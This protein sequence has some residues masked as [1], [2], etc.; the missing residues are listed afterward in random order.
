MSTDSQPSFDL[1]LLPSYFLD[2]Q[3]GTDQ[4]IGWSPTGSPPKPAAYFIAGGS[5][6]R[7]WQP[8]ASQTTVSLDT[9][10]QE[11]YGNA[12]AL[13]RTKISNSTTLTASEKSADLSKIDAAQASL[14][15]EF[16]GLSI[17]AQFDHIRGA[18]Q[19]DHCAVVLQ[20][21]WSA[22]LDTWL[23]AEIKMGFTW[24]SLDV[25][26]PD[27]VLQLL[28]M[29]NN[30]K[31]LEILGD[32]CD[33]LS[34]G[35]ELIQFI[36]YA[37]K[38]WN[39]AV[40]E[41]CKFVDDGGRLYFPVVVV[42]GLVRL[43]SCVTP[44]RLPSSGN[45]TT[46]DL[47]N[48]RLQWTASYDSSLYSGYYRRFD[49]EV[50]ETENE[51]DPS[52]TT[53]G[54]YRM[55]LPDLTYL[56][57]GNF[58]LLTSKMEVEG[59]SAFSAS[60]LLLD[61]NK[62]L[63]MCAGAAQFSDQSTSQGPPQ[64]RAESDPSVSSTESAE[65]IQAVL[66]PMLG[67]NVPSVGTQDDIVHQQHMQDV[68]QS[69]LTSLVANTRSIS[70]PD[71]ITTTLPALPTLSLTT[72][73]TLAN[74]GSHPT[75]AVAPSGVGVADYVDAS[76][77]DSM[78]AGVLTFA[79]NVTASMSSSSY[80]N[81]QDPSLAVTSNSSHVIEVHGGN[82]NNSLYYNVGTLSGSTLT[83]PSK[84]QDFDKGENPAVVV[85]GSG[86][87]GEFHRDQN[88]SSNQLWWNVGSLDS[89]NTSITWTANGT[90]YGSGGDN[91]AATAVPGQSEAAV[92]AHDRDNT[93]YTMAA[94]IV[95]ATSTSLA[96]VVFQRE[97]GVCT[98]Q[99]PA[100]AVLSSGIVVLFSHAQATN[101]RQQL[102]YSIGVWYSTYVQWIVAGVTTG[103]DGTYPALARRPD[104]TLVLA[105]QDGDDSKLSTCIVNVS[106]PT[107]FLG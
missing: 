17:N 28:G 51:T 32:M 63:R 66:S 15:G 74:S 92:V 2:N 77:A 72:A 94:S 102:Y 25:T 37:A 70:A 68:L 22:A 105:W 34:E 57:G 104:D 9:T 89:N 12:L 1:D 79:S 59:T 76:G 91:P 30:S 42:H 43:L 45:M 88:S 6:Y 97:I 41:W 96:T 83:M 10:A 4:P 44:Q 67:P 106:L 16:P 52:R 26:V 24:G 60:L 90:K 101:G 55:S 56:A 36:E 80:Q 8:L 49:T 95:G 69:F 65:L 93:L 81:G 23:P 64:W 29:P 86:A 48:L 21:F 27:D 71:N 84:G 31:A 13:L 85:V 19:D 61:R 33:T 7:L 58:T 103:T 50:Q 38:A 39:F 87:I 14:G 82:G 3:A 35:L 47:D 107:G 18:Q 100:I 20:V 73:Q 53:V 11:A 5:E 40:N 75:V 62:Q 46:V 98:G 78:F 99:A 54:K